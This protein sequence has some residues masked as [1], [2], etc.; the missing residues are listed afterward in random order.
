MAR[1]ASQSRPANCH[2]PINIT[3]IQEILPQHQNQDCT[4]ISKHN[5]K[6]H[7]VYCLSHISTSLISLSHLKRAHLFSWAKTTTPNQPFLWNLPILVSTNSWVQTVY[8]V[9]WLL[10][11][12]W[13]LTCCRVLWCS[14]NGLVLVFEIPKVPLSSFADYLAS[15]IVFDVNRN[16]PQKTRDGS[17]HLSPP[18]LI[19]LALST[20][21]HSRSQQG[22][23]YRR[24]MPRPPRPRIA[25]PPR[26]LPAMAFA[27]PSPCALSDCT[28]TEFSTQ[29]QS[30]L[31]TSWNKSLKIGSHAKYKSTGTFAEN[32][33]L[34]T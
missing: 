15:G 11:K 6:K 9:H 18:K 33:N 32:K 2:Y 14:T 3:G 16:D 26:P 34:F 8:N 25:I 22:D 21:S 23:I 27:A 5:W 7:D 24:R 31:R 13:N 28:K 1:S 20:L 30:A 4:P 12:A 19:F 29:C 10:R 17:L